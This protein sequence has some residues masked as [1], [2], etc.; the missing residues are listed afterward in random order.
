MISRI[1]TAFTEHPAS[2]NESYGEHLLFA[3]TFAGKLGFAAYAALVHAILPFAYQK[4][5]SKIIKELYER[6]HNRGA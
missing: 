1:Q 5:A 2:V 4:T 6:T 3:L